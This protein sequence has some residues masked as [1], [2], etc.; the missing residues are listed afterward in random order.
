MKFVFNGG[1]QDA[2]TAAIGRTD[3]AAVH[4][5]EDI[6]AALSVYMDGAE[7]A[8][9]PAI[10]DRLEAALTETL[11]LSTRLRSE[12]YELPTRID[13]LLGLGTLTAANGEELARN[14]R[15]VADGLDALVAQLR[16]G[17][18]ACKRRVQMG[19]CERHLLR[20]LG[21]AWRNRLNVKP[22]SSVDSAFPKFLQVLV[23]IVGSRFP[24]W[25]N[26]CDGLSGERLERLLQS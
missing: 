9:D 21:Q 10:V 17:R 26:F 12:L 14:G 24:D 1:E 2:L 19:Q 18:D 8:S 4:L 16:A 20:D 11:L 3:A 5:I 7:A 25:A 6:E 15:D 23:A 13:Q 22:S